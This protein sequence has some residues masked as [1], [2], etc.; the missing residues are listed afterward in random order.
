MAEYVVGHWLQTFMSIDGVN[1]AKDPL[2]ELIKLE[3]YLGLRHMLTKET[4]VP[5]TTHNF[6]FA[7]GTKSNIKGGYDEEKCGRK[8]PDVPFDQL[9][10]RN[11]FDWV[12]MEFSYW[13]QKE[14]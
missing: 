3:Q 11:Y 9:L 12:G 4:R 14:L 5:C 6:T 1:F 2:P 8:H 7:N 10:I 13:N